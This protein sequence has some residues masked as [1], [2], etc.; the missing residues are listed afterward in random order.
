MAKPSPYD[1]HEVRRLYYQA[2]VGW[3]KE[4]RNIIQFGLRDGMSILEVGSGPGFITKNL[5]EIAPN[6]SITCVEMDPFLLRHAEQYLRENARC[7]YRII[8]AD[9]MKTELPDDTYDFAFVRLVLQYIPDTLGFAKKIYKALKPGGKLVITEPDAD[10]GPTSYPTLPHARY[11]LDKSR[12]AQ[13]AFGAD[14]MLG[15][16]LWRLL[17][18]AG[19]KNIDVD[20]ATCHSG[21]KGMDWCYPAFDPER[22]WDL[23]R[24]GFVTEQ[25]LEEYREV[26]KEFLASEDPFYLKVLLMACG[27]K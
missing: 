24:A 5:S 15:R 22:V 23:V 6:G 19:Y 17:K 26:I 18:T 12:Q 20:A 11:I 14:P 9:I 27:E 21:T 25:E 1:E 16:K 7:E 8:D 4:S 10:I 13:V 3:D 2:N